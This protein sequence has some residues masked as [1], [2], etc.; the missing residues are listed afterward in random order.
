MEDVPW[1]AGVEPAHV[2]ARCRGDG[3]HDATEGE[4]RPQGG[5]ADGEPLLNEDGEVL[6]EEECGEGEEK[7]KDYQVAYPRVCFGAR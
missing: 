3:C 5:V 1:D 7:A 2:T 6:P 4:D